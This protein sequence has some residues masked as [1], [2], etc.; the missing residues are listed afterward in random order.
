MWWMPSSCTDCRKA[1]RRQNRE[2]A[3]APCRPPCDHRRVQDGSL[4]P[5][6]GRAQRDPGE[7]LLEGFHAVK[8]ALRFGAEIDLLVTP[9]LDALL[10]LAG[11]RAPDVREPLADLARVVEAEL[12]GQL[13]PLPPN[14]GVV[15]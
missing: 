6:F 13:V 1:S 14:T 2:S 10:A 12:F 7:A 9:G 11:R 5:G 15:A 8:H 4:I 3:G